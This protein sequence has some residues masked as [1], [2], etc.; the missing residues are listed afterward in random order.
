MTRFLLVRHGE[1]D[2]VGKRIAGRLQGIS[3][4]AL[5]R[6]QA[7]ELVE[8]L[9]SCEITAILSS[10]MERTVETAAPLAKERGMP[11]VVREGLNEVDY[12]EWSGL[13]FDELRASPG[14]REFNAFRSGIR[15]PGGELIS[16]VQ[17]RMI[18]E[19]EQLG[20]AYPDSTLAVFSHGDPIKT[21][22]AHA[23]GFP[24]D[25]IT[26]MTIS[27]AS[28]SIVDVSRYG[29]VVQGVNLSGPIDRF[30]S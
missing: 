27:T 28:V 11:V 18:G 25:L 2:T 6:Q 19:L 16:E 23:M 29:P 12:G 30:R 8:R 24:L 10:P 21:A 15:I 26:R 3:L 9:R 17:T 14:W 7:R 4:N 22:L 20:R 1:N 5:G 13:S